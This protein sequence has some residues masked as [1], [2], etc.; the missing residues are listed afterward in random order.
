M[1]ILFLDDNTE[2]HRTFMQKTIGCV[3]R[4]AYTS[5]EAIEFLRDPSQKFDIVMLDHDLNEWDYSYH[6]DRHSGMTMAEH[7]AEIQENK[8]K[9]LGNGQTVAEFMAT[10]ACKHLPRNLSIVIHSL[11][12]YGASAMKS[13]L[14]NAGY[15]KVTCLP[16]AWRHLAVRKGD[17]FDHN[18]ITVV[19]ENLGG[20]SSWGPDC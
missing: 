4:Q 16:F 20:L 13:I 6:A 12:N 5:A 9:E 17:G 19:L 2:R 15:T 11:N 10:D 18:R 14:E 7:I 8:F 3:R 1:N